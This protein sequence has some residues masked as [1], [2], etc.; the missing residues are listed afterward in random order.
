[1]WEGDKPRESIPVSGTKRTGE[2]RDTRNTERGKTRSMD[3]KAGRTRGGSAV[4]RISKA[5]GK[6]PA[7]KN[8]SS[9]AVWCQGEN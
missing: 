7:R 9:I 4:K 8:G 6:K 2:W 5:V 3:L 1:M